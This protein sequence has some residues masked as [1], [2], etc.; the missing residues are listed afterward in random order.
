MTQESRGSDAPRRG[1]KLSPSEISVFCSQISIFLRAGITLVEGIGL[2]LEDLEPGRLRS[3]VEL[4]DKALKD[5][6]DLRQA[7]GEA[8]AFPP[9]FVR[10]VG[11]G[12]TSGTL[13]ETMA[14]ISGYYEREGALKQRIRNAVTYPIVLV[15]MMTAVV[16]LLI[17][18]V[19][20]T[21]DSILRSM[22]QS[23]PP[24]VRGLMDFGRFLGE[25]ALAVAAVILIA[26][27][28]L[29][30]LSKTAGGRAF[31]DMLRVCIPFVRSVTQKIAAER[32]ATAMSF[33]LKSDIDI[34][35]AVDMSKE[36]VGNSYMTKKIDRCL[37][38]SREGSQI[39]DAITDAGIFPKLFSRML[40]IGMKTGDLDKIMGQLSRIYE[41]EADTALRR[42]TAFIEPAFVAVLSVIVGVILVSVMLPLINIMSS[43]G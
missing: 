17:V 25:N 22:G 18:R 13:D 15:C 14:S 24:F 30:L 9:Y 42:L 16:M 43:I 26:A 5:R 36:L 10:M 6:K 27:L 34:E 40:S 8:D 1:R 38:L 39:F 28:G 21:F 7:V 2:L 20:P 11:V 35:E 33:L 32:F 41:Q 31:F 29:S 12:E 23:M 3:A 37:S 4:I 19:L